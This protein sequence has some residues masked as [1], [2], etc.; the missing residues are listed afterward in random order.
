MLLL[1]TH[2]LISTNSSSLEL[3]HLCIKKNWQ[4]V[5]QC[6]YRS[7]E[8]I[9]SLYSC[10]QLKLSKRITQGNSE[11]CSVPSK[12]CSVNNGQ[13]RNFPC[14]M[15]TTFPTIIQKWWL[16]PFM[17]KAKKQR[18]TSCYVYKSWYLQV[19]TTSVFAMIG[20]YYFG[21]TLDDF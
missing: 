3:W 10:L 13:K 2:D 16:P 14:K 12:L 19:R 20:N 8:F 15:Y 17:G 21:P 5:E 4:N 11:M 6:R 1:S 9:L 7:E 18:V